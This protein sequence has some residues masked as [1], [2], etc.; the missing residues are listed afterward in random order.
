MDKEKK[1]ENKEIKIDTGIDQS[2]VGVNIDY[3]KIEKDTFVTIQNDIK[4]VGSGAPTYQPTNYKEQFYFQ[5]NG[6]MWVNINNVWRS[7]GG[8]NIY[9]GT[10]TFTGSQADVV[11][12]P[13]FTPK[14]IKVVAI[15]NSS[16]AMALSI[17]QATPD[18]QYSSVMYEYVL[19]GGGYRPIAEDS[20]YIINCMA[21][22]GGT[23]AQASVSAW[24]N[25]SVTIHFYGTSYTVKYQYEILG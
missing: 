13:G 17:G 18:M 3:E 12:T 16:T 2:K 15:V 7:M 4:K 6:T 25:E 1:E 9:V 23:A 5:D 8:S 21:D 10:S 19:G 11:F 24:D 14:H 20:E 22:N